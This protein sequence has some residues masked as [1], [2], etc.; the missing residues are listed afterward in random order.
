MLCTPCKNVNLSEKIK[1]NEM[2]RACNMYGG[3]ERSMQGVGGE[4]RGNLAVVC[5]GA[6]V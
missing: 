4:T 6:H 1:Q 2:G 3:G 5:H